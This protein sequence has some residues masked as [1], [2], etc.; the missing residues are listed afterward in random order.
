MI[1]LLCFGGHRPTAMDLAQ[2][3]SVRANLKLLLSG[4]A[5]SCMVK[6]AHLLE[7]IELLFNPPHFYYASHTQVSQRRSGA[8]CR[9]C[10]PYSVGQGFTKLAWPFRCISSKVQQAGKARAVPRTDSKME[11]AWQL[12]RLAA[13]CPQLQQ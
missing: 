11:T 7:E 12:D 13:R 10:P 2:G 8:P 6:G 9:D 3:S 5:C 1:G 4:F